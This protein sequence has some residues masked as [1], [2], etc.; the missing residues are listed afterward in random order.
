MICHLLRVLLLEPLETVDRFLL[1]EVRLIGGR[2]G[3]VSLFRLLSRAPRRGT[4]E[5]FCVE[6]FLFACAF[7]PRGYG[8]FK[9]ATGSCNRNFQ[10]TSALWY[11]GI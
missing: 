4:G 5:V 11:R 7:S 8:I 9:S 1:G 10:Y 3:P 2:G 6:P